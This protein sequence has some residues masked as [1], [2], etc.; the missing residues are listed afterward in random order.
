MK[1]KEPTLICADVCV[2][3]HSDP[4]FLI[5]QHFLANS[6]FVCSV[7]CFSK[8]RSCTSGRAPADFCSS[9]QDPTRVVSPV[10]DIINMDTFAY[11]AASADLRGGM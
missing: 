7:F 11:V 6:A 3:F 9:V 1:A 5:P 10:I 2:C 8:G 4:V